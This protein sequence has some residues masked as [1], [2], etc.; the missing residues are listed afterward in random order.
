MFRSVLLASA[1]LTLAACSSTQRVYEVTEVDRPPEYLGDSL[2]AEVERENVRYVQPERV[3][4]DRAPDRD[5][6]LLTTALDL[7]FDFADEAVMGTARHTLTPLR[8]SLASDYF[9]AEAMDIAAVRQVVDGRGVGVGYD[10]DSM[11]I[12]IT[13][14]APLRFGETYTF[15]VDYIAHPGRGADQGGVSAKKGGKGVYFIDAAGTDPYRPTQL[16]TQGEAQDNR[17]WFPTWDYPNDRQAFEIALTVPDSMQTFSNGALVEQTD[18]EG[19]L[20]RDRWVLSG[21]QVSYLAAFAAGDFAAV[22]DSVVST[23]GRTIPLAYVVEPGVE[24]EVP[25]IFG[26]TP[27]MMSFYETY[28]GVPYPWDNYKQVAVRDYTFGGMENTSVTILTENVQTDEEARLDYDA[29]DLIAHELAHQWFGDL[30]TT[31]DWA[32]ITLN[33]SFASYLE[34][35]YLEDALGRDA[36]QAHSITDR[37]AYFKQAE[38]LRRPI[39]WY[40]YAS[41]MPDMFDQHSYQKGAQVLN[42]LRFELGDAAFRRGLERYLTDNAYGTAELDDLRQAF[43]AATGRSLRR[44][45]DQGWRQ[46]GHPVL[47]VEQAYFAG[48]GLY[49]VQVVQQQSR[50]EAPVYHFDANIEI[51]YPNRPK[52]VHRVRVTS[53][54]QTFRFDVPQ[55]P[56]FVRFNEGNWVLAATTLQQP[57]DETLAQAVADDELAGRYDAVVT[58]AARDLNAGIREVLVEAATED[59]HPLVRERAVEALAKY[60]RIDEV[61]QA[62]RALAREDADPSVRRAALK[63]LAPADTSAQARAML[64]AALGDPSGQ[65]RAEAVKLYAEYAR[66]DAFDAFQPLLGTT[67]YRG[68]VEEALVKAI[69]GYRLGGDAG[70]RYLAERAGVMNPNDVRIAAVNGL[71]AWARRDDEVRAFAVQTLN[72][73]VDEGTPKVRVAVA[74]ALAE[75]GDAASLAALEA[76]LDA[77]QDETAK[78]A[79]EGAVERVRKGSTQVG[80]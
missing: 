4:P 71:L 69:S 58:L 50:E 14:R 20:R 6:D 27:A 49:T 35:L 24:A 66:D 29:R 80:G 65:T 17:R 76:Q 43:E 47:N 38:T 60:A 21:D 34:E 75:I 48:S 5:Y 11:R 53:A 16:W 77:E 7:R 55:R 12:T 30:V 64:R 45:F 10:A 3:T 46:P 26:E 51:N 72:P 41:P 54:D 23:S 74:H 15:V 2:V 56:S 39:V 1:L 61:Q 70:T 40:G 13:P 8:D 22:R 36:A 25:A 67:S 59:A 18:V 52:E 57:L 68:R 73:L 78:A 37:L 42:Q 31:E 44:F 19:G 63:T 32:N 79:L 62:L 9:N 28:L 33:E